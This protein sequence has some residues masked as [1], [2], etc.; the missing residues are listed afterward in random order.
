MEQQNEP[1]DAIPIE[2]ITSK[3]LQVKQQVELR[4]EAIPPKRHLEQT[5][6]D[7]YLQKNRNKVT[8]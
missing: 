2:A 8:L 7:N 4:R 5:V 1:V 3:A 6:I